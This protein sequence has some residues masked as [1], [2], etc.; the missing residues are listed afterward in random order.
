MTTPAI[1]SSS[2]TDVHGQQELPDVLTAAHAAVEQQRQ[3]ADAAEQR[4]RDDIARIGER[5]IQEADD[6]GWCRVY[7]RVI[8][9]LNEDLTIELPLRERVFDV[10]TTIELRI[11]VTA[12]SEEAA[13]GLAEDLVRT[14][15]SRLD[16]MSSITAFPQAAD[17]YEVDPVGT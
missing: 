1:T 13:R 14:A 5:L 15:E 16:A 7:D 6:R 12:T 10:T 3:R 4:H 8:D 17:N 2:D 11:R 9:E